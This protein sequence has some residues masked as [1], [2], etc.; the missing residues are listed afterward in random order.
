[1]PNR[2]QPL[3]MLQ[4]ARLAFGW[5]AILQAVQED[6]GVPPT[7]SQHYES[8]CQLPAAGSCA[9]GCSERGRSESGE[10]P[11]PW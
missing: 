1:M 4:H 10:G 9:W 3:C 11:F 7:E 2:R 6:V 8:P 5:H